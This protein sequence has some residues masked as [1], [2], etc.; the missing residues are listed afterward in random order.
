[1]TTILED[2]P[3]IRA[4]AP[5]IYNETGSNRTVGPG[6]YD[7]EFSHSFL[8]CQAPFNSTSRRNPLSEADPAI[9]GPDAYIIGEEKKGLGIVSCPFLSED[10]RFGFKVD[11]TPGP[12]SY[13]RPNEWPTKKNPRVHNFPSV[14]DRFPHVSERSVDAGS[15]HPN[16]S[17][18]HRAHPRASHFGKYSE[19]EPLKVNNNP[20]P[21]EYNINQQPRS[22]YSSKPSSMFATNTSRCTLAASATPGPG[23]YDVPPLFSERRPA[24]TFSAFGSAQSR[25]VH[26][27]DEMPGPGAYTGEIAP[28]RPKLLGG[29]TSN[30]ASNM[31][32]FPDGPHPS[33]GPG[34]YNGGRLPKHISHGGVAPFG[35]TVPRFGLNKGVEHSPSAGGYGTHAPLRFPRRIYVPIQRIRSSAEPAM[36][37]RNYDPEKYVAPKPTS[38]RDTTFG[39]A[40]RL[41][42]S[43]K[44]S[45]SPAPGSYNPHPSSFGRGEGRSDWG[46]EVR[47]PGSLGHQNPGPG[48]YYQNGTLLKKTYNSTIQSDT[49]W[50]DKP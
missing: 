25:F 4:K 35:S 22:I 48:E 33:P 29:L 44:S 9:P 37:T 28:R 2:L 18:A 20:G 12:G 1:M 40:P 17:S 49:T 36:D 42:S 14:Y 3:L 39:G 41:V 23:T 19:R 31:E 26:H 15:Y 6:S 5:G 8:H 13:Y 21:G 16:Y 50:L 24:E 47:F 30:F 32:R 7:P 45:Y 10:A 43:I 46:K 11:K 34:A 38:T 27:A